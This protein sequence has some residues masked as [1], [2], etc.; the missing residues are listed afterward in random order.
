LKPGLLYEIDLST[1]SVVRTVVIDPN[2][3]TTDLVITPDGK[4]IVI[5]MY[6]KHEVA[7][8]DAQTLSVVAFIPLTDNNDYVNG[9]AIGPGG[10]HVFVSSQVSGRVH[11]ID[12]DELSVAAVV[13]TG[14]ASVNELAL[15]QNG[16]YI[17]G[18]AGGN[19]AVILID[20]RTFE[21]VENIPVSPYPVGI[22]I[23]KNG[24]EAAVVHQQGYTQGHSLLTILDTRTASVVATLD[25]PGGARRIAISQN[26]HLAVVTTTAGNVVLV[27]I[28]NREILAVEELDPGS[29]NGLFGVAITNGARFNKP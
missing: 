22:A 9:I 10:R 3:S 29:Q 15:T 14:A 23:P 19:D 25:I 21:V 20:A 11:V 2:F 17:Y 8:V 13:E 1:F 26:G 24:R 6:R 28:P 5:T 4:R 27:D 16:Q 18:T 7:V 12:T